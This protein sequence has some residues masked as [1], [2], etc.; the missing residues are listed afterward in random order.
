M[1]RGMVIDMND[2]Q[3]HTLDQ[4]RAFLNGTVAVGF[5]VGANERYEFIARILRR[6]GYSRLRRADRGVVLR[7]LGRVS[8]Y[9]RAQLTRLVG[10]GRRP[11]PLLKQYPAQRIGFKRTFTDAD[12]LLLAHTDTLHGTLSGPATKKL[13]ERAFRMFHEP[14]YERLATISVA[15]LY[16]LRKRSS[17]QRQRRVWTK[18]RPV[19]I[20]IGE[21]RAPAP[22][23][24][25]GYLRLDTV[26]QG[27]Q[28]GVKG[29]YH[30]NAV[31]CVTQYEGVATCERISEAYL[32]PVLAE[33]L[34][35]FPFVILGFHV[36]NGS[37]YINRHVAELLNKLLIE[38]FTKSR[39]R[40]S[41]DNAQAES[42]NGAIVR[43]H[44][45]YSHIPQRF[46]ALVNAFDR[47]YLNPYVNFH[48]PCLFAETITDAKGR[49]RKRYP[50]KLM[51][52]PYEKF[53]SLP[54]A[55]QFLKPRITFI[56]LDVLATA[57]S[58]NEAAERLNKART[59]LFKTIFNRSKTAA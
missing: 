11:G 1:M 58:D 57:M 29:L 28:D 9:S 51:M 10:R 40:H 26:H 44:L 2:A 5:S 53:K 13:M 47:E 6:F 19:T 4:L 17:Y 36:D 18:T 24:R 41:N 15:H 59:T 54:L 42:K 39:S 7:F 32:I 12:V 37:E 49:Q 34:A 56:Q 3:L 8:G 21:R 14:R 31:D 16:N 46:A 25:P 48:R 52:T 33:L 30:I 38:E 55:E 43:K 27:D 20:A 23:N 45:G 22:N 35:S 50:Y